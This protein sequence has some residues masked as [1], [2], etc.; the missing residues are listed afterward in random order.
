MADDSDQKSVDNKKSVYDEANGSDGCQT[1]TQPTGIWQNCER[2]RKFLHKVKSR[3]F[4]RQP[5]DKHVANQSTAKLLQSTA[6]TTTRTNHIVLPT[7]DRLRGLYVHQTAATKCPHNIDI[8]PDYLCLDSTD[9]V[10]S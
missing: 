9:T 3:M 4:T 5:I 8:T 6:H 10:S 7:V 2:N 1:D